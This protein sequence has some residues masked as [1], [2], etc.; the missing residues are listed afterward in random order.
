[1]FTKFLKFK[2]SKKGLSKAG[3]RCEGLTHTSPVSFQSFV[4]E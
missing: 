2:F 1:M 4:P 3:P